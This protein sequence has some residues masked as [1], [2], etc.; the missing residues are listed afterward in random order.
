MSKQRAVRR[1]AREASSA[2]AAA[3]RAGRAARTARRGALTSRLAAFTR[4]ADL[5]ARASRWRAPTGPLTT[6]R[7]RK[8]GLIALGF[9][10]VQALVWA[11]TPDWSIRVAVLV[12]SLF[13]LPVLVVLLP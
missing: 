7:R 5:R 6:R 3:E 1:A 10:V 12:V 13:A 2:D 8:A 11:D 9:V 4:V